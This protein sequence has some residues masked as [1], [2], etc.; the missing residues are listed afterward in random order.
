MKEGL[1]QEIKLP[2]H[3][4]PIMHPIPHPHGMPTTSTI[5]GAGRPK[6]EENPNTSRTPN[7]SSKKSPIQIQF[8]ASS[9]QFQNTV[10]PKLFKTFAPSLI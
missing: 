1:L 9:K 10:N 7:I 3:M 6:G 5:P 8:E 4:A 2:S